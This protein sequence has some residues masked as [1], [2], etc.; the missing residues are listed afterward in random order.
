[1]DVDNAST[2]RRT[3]RGVIDTE[4]KFKNVVT[5]LK[6]IIEDIFE[7]ITESDQFVRPKKGITDE[8][9]KAKVEEKFLGLGL[10]YIDANSKKSMKE[11][12]A[13]S[14]PCCIKHESMDATRARA[15][16]ITAKRIG[17]N[18]VKSKY[19]EYISDQVVK[20]VLEDASL[21][22]NKANEHEDTMSDDEDCQIP[23]RK[24]DNIS[25]CLHT[26][27]S[28]NPTFVQ[29]LPFPGYVALANG[30]DYH[31][32]EGVISEG[33]AYNS[34]ETISDLIKKSI[35]VTLHANITVTVSRDSIIVV[36][37]NQSPNKEYTM[38]DQQ[39]YHMIGYKGTLN[40]SCDR[41]YTIIAEITEFK[42][43]LVYEL[44]R[45]RN[46]EGDMKNK[47]I[48]AIIDGLVAFCAKNEYELVVS[49]GDQTITLVDDEYSALM[50]EMSKVENEYEQQRWKTLFHNQDIVYEW[51]QTKTDSGVAFHKKRFN[52]WNEFIQHCFKAPIKN[53]YLSNVHDELRKISSISDKQEIALQ[54]NTLI[55]NIDEDTAKSITIQG[56]IIN[57]SSY[58][59]FLEFKKTVRVT[60]KQPEKAELN[61]LIVKQGCSD[62]DTNMC[63]KPA[64]KKVT[65]EVNKET[66][67]NVD[68]EQAKYKPHKQIMAVSLSVELFRFL[69]F[70]KCVVD[71]VSLTD[72]KLIYSQIDCAKILKT[73]KSEKDIESKVKIFLE[74]REKF[75]DDKPRSDTYVNTV[76]AFLK[77]LQKA[78][79][80]TS[81]E[82]AEQ[83]DKLK[84]LGDSCDDDEPPSLAF[85]LMKYGRHPPPT[86]TSSA[87][88]P[89]AEEAAESAPKHERP[90]SADPRRGKK[91]CTRVKSGGSKAA[92]LLSAS[93]HDSDIYGSLINNKLVA[94]L[95]KRNGMRQGSKMT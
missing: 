85:Y 7:K 61:F 56:M 60:L 4:E 32:Y 37:S 13:S 46:G 81:D 43:M 49:N 48:S 39:L 29:P 84:I 12:D 71:V 40:T 64:K 66:I 86:P 54:D 79:E 25:V 77:E 91:R 3:R 75:E 57:F 42:C 58:E 95:Q 52:N 44:L 38:T 45:L 23:E 72:S 21:V 26:V 78:I 22:V 8:I 62:D 70:L 76:F 6:K 59:N 89:N 92:Q 19:Y 27:D 24:S 94:M 50:N 17:F 82:I 20:L 68:K 83:F 74:T 65:N 41:Y 28:V 18:T 10:F 36:L 88:K 73:L 63:M 14:R 51:L 69:H 31:E 2:G 16:H 90:C 15:K 35:T 5:T 34:S 80:F 67:V 1:M 53:E 47:Y 55:T 87:Q 11:E 9:L 33:E 30:E 93:Q